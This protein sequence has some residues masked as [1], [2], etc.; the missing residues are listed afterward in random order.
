MTW[1]G[2]TRPGGAIDIGCAEAAALA[3]KPKTRMGKTKRC[4]RTLETPLSGRM[5]YRSKQVPIGKPCAR[6]RIIA[7]VARALR[8]V[9][10]YFA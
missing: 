6:R 9:T 10:V 2:K 7:A 8:R 5:E 4:I 1:G 3:N